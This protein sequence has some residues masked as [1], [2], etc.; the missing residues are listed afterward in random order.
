MTEHWVSFWPDVRNK[1]P[2]MDGSRCRQFIVALWSQPRPQILSPEIQGS[3]IC[4]CTAG[5]CRNPFKPQRPA[6]RLRK[7]IFKVECGGWIQ[8]PAAGGKAAFWRTICTLRPRCQDGKSRMKRVRPWVSFALLVFG[9]SPPPCI[10]TAINSG[11]HRCWIRS[12][13][14]LKD[15]AFQSLWEQLEDF[16]WM[17]MWSCIEIYIYIYSMPV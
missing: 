17:V 9:F 15:S 8:S 16:V 2:G 1:P 12:E 5:G 10:T 11:V 3:A 4:H 13:L 6:C 7:A 14:T